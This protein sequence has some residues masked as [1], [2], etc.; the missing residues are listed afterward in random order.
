MLQAAA[1][2]ARRL[3]SGAG[4]TAVRAPPPPAR[5]TAAAG[6][7]WR[8]APLWPPRQAHLRHAV[9]TAAA[10]RAAERPARRQQQFVQ[11]E[12]DGSDAWRLEP[13]IEALK[14][15]AVGIIPT[16]T[17]WA[18]SG[19]STQRAG[20]AASAAGAGTSSPAFRAG[21]RGRP[22]GYRAALPIHAA[23]GAYCLLELCPAPQRPFP[24]RLPACPHLAPLP[25]PRC[26]RVCLPAHTAVAPARPARPADSNLAFVCD[27]GNRSAVEKLLEI[28]GARGSQRMSILCRSLQDVDAY[29]QGWPPSRAPGQPDM[30]KLVKRVL[31]GPVRRGRGTGGARGAPAAA[32]CLLV[33]C[34]AGSSRGVG[35]DQRTAEPPAAAQL[36]AAPAHVGGQFHSAL[37]PPRL[38]AA[39]ACSTP[40]SC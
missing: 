4:G 28:K 7:A 36:L 33:F 17:W 20:A 31:P 8:A 11:V 6:G 5:C 10:A 23:A 26:A 14:E 13:V 39:P 38:C 12:P 35:M 9:A 19:R 29:T 34:C 1:G 18:S 21:Q 24:S 25:T 32:A 3:V 37:L 15:G 30:F 40:S 2:V 22:P 27:L 16:G